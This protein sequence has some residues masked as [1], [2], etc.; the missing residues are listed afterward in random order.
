MVESKPNSRVAITY[1]VETGGTIEQRTLPFVVGVLADLFGNPE[2]PLPRLKDH[3]RK[4]VE[5]DQDNFND[6]MKGNRP[7]LAFMVENKFTGDGS[8]MGIELVFNSIDDFGPEGVARQIP[9]LRE[10]IEIRSQLI[11]L[12][13]K[14]DGND[15]LR[16]R[17]F[18]VLSDRELVARIAKEAGLEESDAASDSVKATVGSDEAIFVL[19]QI[20]GEARIGWDDWERHTSRQQIGT[21][22]GEFLKGTLRVSREI[23]TTVNARIA[24]IERLVSNQLNEVFHSSQFQALEASWRGLYYLVFQ[25]ETNSE[26]KIRVLNVSKDELRLDQ[27]RATDYEQSA[28]YKKVYEEEYGTFAGAPYAVLVG[29]YYFGRNPADIYL[30]QCI[31]KVAA[32]A[33]A[34]FL[35]AAAPGLLGL[36]SFTE[37]PH[38]RDLS[39]K[40]E[41][42]DYANW[43]L[44]RDS[45]DSRYVGLTLPHVLM[46]LPYGPDTVSVETFNSYEDVDGSDHSK[47]LWGNAAYILAAR[48]TKAFH[49][50]GWCAKIWGAETGGLIGDL[51]Q[52]I[53]RSDSGDMLLKCPT[54]V[55]ISDHRWKELT[56]LGFIAL[57]HDKRSDKAILFRVPSC[58]KPRY[59]DKDE[60]TVTHRLAVRLE[61]VMAISRF[62]HY[63]KAILRDKIG[64]HMSRRDCEQ[65]LGKWIAQYVS[66]KDPVTEEDEVRFPLKS[67]RLEIQAVLGKPG[68]YRAIVFL[69]PR[70]QLRELSVPLRLVTELPQPAK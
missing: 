38:P 13:V 29:D 59:F 6:V 33:H 34:P 41:T 22:I 60:A 44:F 47:Y 46:R 2:L 7:R 17:L 9:P 61:Y 56:N 51:P 1:D 3:K 11:G 23:E 40:F 45:E 8:K 65:S 66:A 14:M 54:E 48:L 27:E 20:I 16:K 32:A 12:L 18:D 52:H 42:P 4:F 43:K 10:L 68:Y 19:D 62:A 57:C 36:E 53:F 67:A 28:L 5:I 25:T 69:Q 24:D 35:S 39:K 26:L 55:S 58:E 30:L 37:L 50:Y 63:L 70:F 49:R 31:A 64:L 21:L 15:V